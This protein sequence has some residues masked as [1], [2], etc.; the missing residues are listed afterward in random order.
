MINAMIS[1]LNVLVGLLSIL[2]SLASIYC[3]YV[4]VVTHHK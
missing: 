4:M 2:G 1:L 3:W